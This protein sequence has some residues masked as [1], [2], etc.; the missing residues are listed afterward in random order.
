MSVPPS[1][2]FRSPTS[3][4][5]WA[6]GGRSVRSRASGSL[7]LRA[8]KLGLCRLGRSRLRSSRMR[9]AL[10]AVPARPPRAGHPLEERGPA[11]RRYF[12]CV[13]TAGRSGRA[14]DRRRSDLPFGHPD[15]G[16]R[17]LGPPRLRAPWP[18]EQRTAL[19]GR[20]A[21]ASAPATVARAATPPEALAA[22]ALCSCF[23][24]AS[25]DAGAGAREV[26]PGRGVVE[27]GG[28]GL[29]STTA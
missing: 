23:A 6:A 3:A 25:G 11:G 14:L 19:T 4:R 26:V 28:A 13:R 5:P 10:G 27:T 7:F 20:W 18:R 9:I 12:A 15:F 29:R 24:R 21:F 17:G 1:W 22:T 16:R 8:V 2:A